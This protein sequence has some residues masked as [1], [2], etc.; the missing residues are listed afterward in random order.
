MAANDANTNGFRS[1]WPYCLDRLDRADALSTHTNRT[2]RSIYRAFIVWFDS[3]E[4]DFF[5]M[6]DSDHAR[7]RPLET[8]TSA[9]GTVYITQD[10]VD[11]YFSTHLINIPTSGPA[12]MRRK[13]SGLN[14][15]LQNIEDV[16]CRNPIQYS[17]LI[18]R[19]MSTQKSD[20][21]THKHT[22][23]AGCDP[24]KGLKDPISDE[25]AIRLVC[26]IWNSRTDS[27]S[28]IFSFTWGFNAGIRGGSTRKLVLADL[29]IS[30]AFGPDAP[31]NLKKTLLVVLRKGNLHKERHD[32]DKQVGLQRNR[33]YRKCTVFATSVLVIMKLR[34]LDHLISFER[35]NTDER[36][37][38]WDI[39]LTE[40]NS[41]S[42]ESSKMRQALA[43][44]NLEDRYSKVTHHRSMMVQYAGSRGLQPY[45]ISSLTKHMLDKMHSAYQPE[46]EE[47]TLKVMSGFRKS[48]TRFVCT[49]H[50]R[51]QG[52]HDQYL[53]EGIGYLLPQ[54][55]R[56]IAEYH[57]DEGDKSIL[58]TKFLFELLP[59]FV[60]TVMQCG[61]WFIRD[62]PDHMF[63][64]VL[65]VST[66]H[67]LLY[68]Y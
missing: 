13:M 24:H 49:E 34:E 56:Y 42:E 15:V 7:P 58:S 21:N 67:F 12:C 41:Y 10:N 55:D 68:W 51:F 45:Q 62:F 52:D 57:S 61:Y 64:Q 11:L 1:S 3:K 4:H 35:G 28:L 30:S 5:T 33:D 22:A 54:Y 43:N 25:E 48:E 29:N 26:S 44:S 40:Y 14:Y 63:T 59:F 36:A 2:Y 66:V 46:V 16:G 17:T 47:E 6:V 18:V 39:P 37:T 53:V 60:E 50:V 65:K 27:I 20:Y 19:A 23:H 38:W 8:R 31:K 32:T 9:D